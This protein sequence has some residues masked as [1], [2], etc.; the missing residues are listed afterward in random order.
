VLEFR[1][2]IEENEA[3][4]LNFVR[5]LKNLKFLFANDNNIIDL[6]P[7]EDHQL[8]EAEL[9][10]NSISDIG[11][12]QESK[13]SLTNLALSGN[14]FRDKKN[15]TDMIS[16]MRNL[17]NITL[18]QNLLR[19]ITFLTNLTKLTLINLQGNNIDDVEPLVALIHHLEKPEKMQGIY[20]H[21][22][23]FESKQI[24]HVLGA[25][26]SKGV[27]LEPDDDDI[28]TRLTSEQRTQMESL[29]ERRGGIGTGDF[30]F[31]NQTVIDEKFSFLKPLPLRNQIVKAIVADKKFVA[32]L[33]Y[34]SPEEQIER[35]EKYWKDKTEQRDTGK[36]KAK[37]EIEEE[38]K[39]L[40]DFWITEKTKNPN[41]TAFLQ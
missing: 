16:G 17:E 13:E 29:L 12:L 3:D 7:L 5:D 26:I 28:L 18:G 40:Q 24:D 41:T 14:K 15:L 20:I 2:D 19:D 36:G 9:E 25:L 21:D 11:A 22:N 1:H 35:A 32:E 31:L 6:S 34:L 23:R 4:N 27:L 10:R 38:G 33:E 8:I 30:D 39:G 37:E